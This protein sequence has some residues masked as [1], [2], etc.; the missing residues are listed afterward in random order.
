MRG[1]TQ[2]VFTVAIPRLQHLCMLETIPSPCSRSAGNCREP[3]RSRGKFLRIKIKGRD[4]NERV[5]AKVVAQIIASL[6]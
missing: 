4:C 5:D 2:L 6:Q 3:S 1:S